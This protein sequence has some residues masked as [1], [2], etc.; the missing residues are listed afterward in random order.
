MPFNPPPITPNY[1]ASGI[2]DAADSIAEGLKEYGRRKKQFEATDVMGQELGLWMKGEA[3]EK[4]FTLGQMVGRLEASV[5]KKSDEDRQQ[6]REMQRAQIDSILQN[7]QLQKDQ[8]DRALA[9]NRAVFD[10]M[11]GRGQDQ[12]KNVPVAPI[13]V[14]NPA[15]D[16]S[17]LEQQQNAIT[18]I[19]GQRTQ[20]QFYYPDRPNRTPTNIQEAQARFRDQVTQQTGQGQLSN[21]AQEISRRQGLPQT[22]AQPQPDRQVRMTE[23]EQQQQILQ[24]LGANP[25]IDPLAALQAMNKLSGPGDLTNFVEGGASYNSQTGAL[26]RSLLPK[27]EVEVPFRSKQ[28]TG[29]TVEEA[30]S[31]R[32]TLANTSRAMT[33]MEELQKHDWSISSMLGATATSAQVEGR[34]AVLVGALKPFFVG[35]GPLSAEDQAFIERNLGDPHKFSWKGKEKARLET[36]LGSL[37]LYAQNEIRNKTVEGTQMTEEDFRLLLASAQGRAEGIPAGPAKQVVFDPASR[38]QLSK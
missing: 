9:T 15:A 25:N 36:I 32:S 2:A 12:F 6:Q 34:R 37:R 20:D 17:G 33:E 11:S 8:Y 28:F 4:K 16:I 10:M 5:I 22:V 1:I 14:P 38:K 30:K 26:T 13:D 3:K 35:E 18:R 31:L 27:R 29:R 23:Q 19:L 21:L 7:N 24:G